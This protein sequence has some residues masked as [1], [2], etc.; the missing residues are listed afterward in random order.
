[1]DY[2]GRVD[3]SLISLCQSVM[4]VRCLH[5]GRFLFDCSWPRMTRCDNEA[6]LNPPRL[7]V[8]ERSMKRTF[9]LS[10][11]LRA[12]GG[13]HLGLELTWRHYRRHHKSRNIT[14]L[15][16]SLCRCLVIIFP[17]KPTRLP[18]RWLRSCMSC[19]W[20][21]RNHWPLSRPRPWQRPWSRLMIT[22]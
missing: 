19:R 14:N 22:R 9:W 7:K 11:G 3:L 17:T 20:P 10:P 8:P 12:L 21:R 6:Y 13:N 4:L 5:S 15:H 18:A 16:Y 1:M 2:T